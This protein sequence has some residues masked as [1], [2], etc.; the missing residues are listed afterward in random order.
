ML[1]ASRQYFVNLVEVGEV[2]RIE[3]QHIIHCTVK[4]QSI[5][6]DDKAH[7]AMT[8]VGAAIKCDESGEGLISIC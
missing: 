7:M 3:D 1:P 8:V 5:N 4:A 2:V 6:G